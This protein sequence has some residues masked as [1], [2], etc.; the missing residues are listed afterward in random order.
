MRESSPRVP[1]AL[2]GH[3]PTKN[4]GPL[5]RAPRTHASEWAKVKEKKHLLEK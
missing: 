2:R 5:F 1:R 3:I 4:V